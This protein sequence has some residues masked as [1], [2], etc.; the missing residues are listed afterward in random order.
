MQNAIGT[1][2]LQGKD[3][4]RNDTEFSFANIYFPTKSAVH[5]GQIQ[6]RTV[7]EPDIVLVTGDSDC[8]HY[9][10]NKKSMFKKHPPDC[11]VFLIPRNSA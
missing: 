2:E 10:G 4:I 11:G 3:L 9:I 8:N 1:C 6:S 5:L 7:D